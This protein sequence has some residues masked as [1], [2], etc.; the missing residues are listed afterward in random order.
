MDGVYAK[1]VN[2]KVQGVPQAQPQPTPWHQEE[3]EN[4]KKKKKKKKRIDTR[5]KQTNKCTRNTRPA[6]SS[7]SEVITMLKGMTKYEDK[8]HGKTLK[9]ETPRSINH[10]ATK[11]KNNTETTALERSVA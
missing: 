6:P 4:E 9:H 8:E 3:K 1:N 5:T 2:R 7:P 10:K 11:N